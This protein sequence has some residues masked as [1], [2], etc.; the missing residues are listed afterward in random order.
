M[1]A[2]AYNAT[3]GQKVYAGPITRVSVIPQRSDVIIS[4]DAVAAATS[5]GIDIAVRYGAGEWP[6]ADA[7]RL[8]D[9]EIWPVCSPRYMEKS[10][11]INSESDLLRHSLLHLNKFPIN[12]NNSRVLSCLH[13]TKVPLPHSF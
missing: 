12:S 9:N 5:E 1:Q 3:S 7:V 11:P 2:Y 8:F 4:D 13:S 6:S 10:S